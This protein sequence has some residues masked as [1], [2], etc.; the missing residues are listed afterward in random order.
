M[1]NAL[2]KERLLIAQDVQFANDKPYSPCRRGIVVKE[3][4]WQDH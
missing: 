3:N 2:S 4:F 1:I